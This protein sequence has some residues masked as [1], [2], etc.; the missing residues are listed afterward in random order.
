MARSSRKR[1]APTTSAGA[2]KRK[3][4]PAPKQ[5][6]DGEG[7]EEIASPT[8]KSQRMASRQRQT[9][10]G[11]SQQRCSQNHING[12]EDVDKIETELEQDQGTEENELKQDDDEEEQEQEQ[13]QEEE[14]DEDEDE[15][16]DDDDEED[17]EMDDGE[18][19][20]ADE[21]Y[22]EG[23]E[24]NDHDSAV[25]NEHERIQDKKEEKVAQNVPNSKV[26][27]PRR[28]S[29][30][31]R[32]SR[33]SSKQPEQERGKQQ[34][35][36]AMGAKS[37][38]QQQNSD[39]SKQ[40]ED[41]DADTDGGDEKKN[42]WEEIR[43][44]DGSFKIGAKIFCLYHGDGTYRPCKVI[45][46]EKKSDGNV[47]YYVH[48]V[49]FNRRMDTWVG[50]EHAKD[51]DPTG[52]RRRENIVR[53][54]EEDYGE[55][56]GM[57]E[58]SIREHEEITKVKNVNMI[59]LGR[60]VIKTWY[61][62]PIPREYFPDGPVDILYMCEFTLNFYKYKDE[63]ERHY[64]KIQ[65]RHPPGDEIYR[66]LDSKIAMFEVDGKKSKFYAQNLCYLAKFFLDHKTLHY[67]VDPFLF[68]VLCEIDE[69]GYHIVGYFS[70]EKYSDQ[71]YNL[72]CILTLPP[73]Q[74]KGYGKFL[75]E[76]S[77]AL[78]KKEE[79]VGS[80]EK[81]LSDLGQ[82][83]YRSYWCRA[84]L[85]ILLET[86]SDL[87]SVIDIAKE[88]SIKTEDVILALKFLRLLKLVDGRYILCADENVLKQKLE[89]FPVKGPR[90]DLNKLHW[91]P[92]I[93]DVKRDKWSVRSKRSATL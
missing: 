46:V 14:E 17:E 82:I 67:D 88:T 51:H 19:E 31:S 80:P 62:S 49:E 81:P 70:K 42:N 20:H 87:I 64:R 56:H 29:V 37:S 10:R 93:V 83:S 38:S 33:S 73:Y 59:E 75:I 40:Q 18:I 41:N 55:S 90:V 72:A 39:K 85:E 65:A 15:D 36:G 60:N 79:K 5:Q 12:V 16:E 44:E 34:S 21:A 3:K 89:Q 50:S 47:R 91:A 58:A 43:D 30:S 11:S 52:K 2:S 76:F 26:T 9:A 6:R 61:Y 45:D 23:D 32:S 13:E 48:F 74:R 24:D 4:A 8:R 77:Y 22:E 78:S 7:E 25:D 53:F 35:H 92:L 66:D 86:K 84:V 63:L 1:K 69:K 28:G 71:G 54:V 27:R 68:Y 57:D